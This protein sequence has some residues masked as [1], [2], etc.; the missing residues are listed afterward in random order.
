MC[1]S[2]G[3]ERARNR[4]CIDVKFLLRSNDFLVFNELIYLLILIQVLYV[5]DHKVRKGQSWTSW[6]DPC[7]SSGETEQRNLCLTSPRLPLLNRLQT[8]SVT[9]CWLSLSQTYKEPHWGTT[10]LG[11]CYLR[12]RENLLLCSSFVQGDRCSPFPRMVSVWPISLCLDNRHVL[13]HYVVHA[14]KEGHYS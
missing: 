12:T 7:L 1:C 5:K 11:F 10:V 3:G 6:L 2:F 14:F 9:G 13:S 4:I 8:K